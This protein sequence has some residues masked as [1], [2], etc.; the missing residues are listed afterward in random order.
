M[1]V[2]G[3][4]FYEYQKK[5]KAQSGGAPRQKSM[6][7]SD[8]WGSPGERATGGPPPATGNEGRMRPG[9]QS[10]GMSFIDVNDWFKMPEIWDKVQETRS[11]YRVPAFV[12]DTLTRPAPSENEAAGQI[13]EFFRIPAASFEGLTIDQAWANVFAPFFDN[14]ER[15]MNQSKPFAIPGGLRFEL[16]DQ[17]ALVLVYRER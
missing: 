5:K 11:I 14:V 16:D 2:E 4:S 9:F 7:D 8:I 12:V 6:F 13:A 15:G 1:G 10:R 3:P 17:K